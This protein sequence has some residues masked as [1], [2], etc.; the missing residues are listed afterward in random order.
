MT[1]AEQFDAV[2]AEYEDVFGEDSSPGLQFLQ[3]ECHGDVDKYFS[4]LRKAIDSGIALQ[5]YEDRHEIP[6]EAL[7]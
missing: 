6:A 4:L 2:N 7:T 1:K 3:I 5:S